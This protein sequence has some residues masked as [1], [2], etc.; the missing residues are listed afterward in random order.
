[1]RLVSAS[2]FIPTNREGTAYSL[3]SCK[4]VSKAMKAI[5]G[6]GEWTFNSA[7]NVSIIKIITSLKE[8]QTKARYYF[9]FF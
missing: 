8:K 7:K 5:W 1:L 4:G 2:R 6:G 3:Q 9:T